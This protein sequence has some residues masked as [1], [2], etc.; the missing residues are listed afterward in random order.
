MISYNDLELDGIRKIYMER[1]T[2][3]IAIVTGASLGIGKGKRYI[4]LN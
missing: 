4:C 3:K 2:D 1:V